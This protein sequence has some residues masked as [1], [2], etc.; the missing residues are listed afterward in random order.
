MAVNSKPNQATR[1]QW[2]SEAAY[3][4]AQALHF[5]QGQELAHWLAAEN[6]YIS[7]QIAYYLATAKEDNGLTI[8]GLQELAASLGIENSANMA[9]KTELI[10]SIQNADHQPRCFRSILNSTCNEQDC[11]WKQECKKLV[12]AWYC[13]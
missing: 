10:Q 5:A 11:Q 7:M 8:R 3:F 4:K 1:H 12:A 9:Q 13:H 6:N 2:I